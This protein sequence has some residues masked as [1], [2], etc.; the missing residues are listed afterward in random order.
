MGQSLKEHQKSI[1]RVESLI[2]Q[3]TVNGVLDIEKA[4][5]KAKR[6]SIKID[7]EWKAIGRG[8]ILVDKGFDEVGEIFLLRAYELG[9]IDGQMEFRNYKLK[10]LNDFLDTLE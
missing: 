3:C 9:G 6:D 2:S 8:K 10:K 1:M 4:I 7:T 5:A